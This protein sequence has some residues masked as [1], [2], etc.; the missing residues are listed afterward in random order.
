MIVSGT[1]V[2]AIS[3][4]GLAVTGEPRATES[5][6]ETYRALDGSIVTMTA[7]TQGALVLAFYST[8]CPISNYYSAT[9]STIASAHPA[10][11]LRVL[12][13]SVDPDATS[14][15]LL[16]HARQ[17][18]LAFP[19]IHDPAGGIARRM[20]VTVTPE[21]IVLDDRAEKRY[22]GRIDD[23]YL[24]RQKKT[25]AP[26]SHDL[27]DAVAAVLAGEP[28]ATPRTRAV[29]CPLPEVREKRAGSVT[30]TRDIAPILYRHCVECH[31]QGSFAPFALDSYEQAR[32]RSADI[33]GLAE[34]RLMPPWRALP[35]FGPQFKHDRSLTSAEIA[36]LAAWS[37]AG[38][39]EGDPADL[40]P[41]PSFAEGWKLGEP[42]LVIEM[43]EEFEVPATGED[44]Y[45]CFVIKTN[46]PD[47]MYVSGIEYR[48][49][50]P[51][52]VHHILGYVDVTEKAREK[53]EADAEPGY[54]CFGGPGVEIN[55]D[56]G[57]WAPGVEASVLPD[58]VGRA[59]PKGSYVIMQVHYHPSGRPETD[60]SRIGLTFARKPVK[61]AFHW[62][63]ALNDEFEI[64][65]G[66]ANH[67]VRAEREIPVDVD[68]YSVAPH[69]HMLGK[70]MTMWAEL[71][72]GERVDLIE[73]DKWDFRWQAQYFFQEPI[74]LPK[75]TMLKVVAHF[76]NSSDNPSNPRRER[77]IPV[78]WGEGTHDEMCI[79]FI[80]LVK[81]GQDLTQPGQE[82]D[83]RKILDQG[84]DRPGGTPRGSTRR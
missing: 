79:G 51:G 33:A 23:Q 68:A 8:E 71:P 35:G 6:R 58:G 11:R 30:Y 31:R 38:S 28:V 36:T 66:A 29:G 63:F 55:N 78:R 82:D 54:A 64:T 9:L 27:A 70:D 34:D 25:A 41:R 22:Q 76:D 60:R 83:L 24:E 50:N 56:L 14:E 5:P 19:A 21:V 67:E 57:G 53:D 26:S 1:F 32:K 17:Y 75:G 69:M 62:S 52:V 3:I 65:P 47:D 4:H 13:V 77:P 42:D 39:P 15:T 49:G 10:S 12:G 45:R 74:R 73:I 72:G 40:P 16:E 81:A 84:R 44:I 43:P 80:G 18:R 37:D 61:Q 48:P 59:L 46:L 2:L 20:G 7:P